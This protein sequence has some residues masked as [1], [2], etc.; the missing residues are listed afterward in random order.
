MTNF[1][2][3]LLQ[4]QT[5]ILQQV[6]IISQC[7]LAAVKDVLFLRHVIEVGNQLVA[8]LE[9]KE[10]GWNKEVGR[11]EKGNRTKHIPI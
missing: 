2:E 6:E 3:L 4:Q 10:K 5:D 11:R 8:M 7:D 1:Q 9:G